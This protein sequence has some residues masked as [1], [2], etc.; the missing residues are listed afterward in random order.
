MRF[1][2]APLLQNLVDQDRPLNVAADRSRLKEVQHRGGSELPKLFLF[3]GHVSGCLC[4]DGRQTPL[5]LSLTGAVKIYQRLA[6]NEARSL[7]LACGEIADGRLRTAAE[8]G[9]L[10]LICPAQLQVGDE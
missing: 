1:F 9:Y 6:D 3:S 5:K 2:P 10:D 7:R 8:G 4:F